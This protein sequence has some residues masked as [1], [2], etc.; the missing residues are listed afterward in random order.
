MPK[1]TPEQWPD[2]LRQIA[3]EVAA[4][5]KKSMKEVLVGSV[6]S[7]GLSL[8]TI[9]N[10]LEK[11]GFEK[12]TAAEF[13]GLKTLITEIADTIEPPRKKAPDKFAYPK[14]LTEFSF[15]YWFNYFYVELPNPARRQ[16]YFDQITN[17][18]GSYIAEAALDRRRLLDEMRREG[19]EEF[20]IREKVDPEVL[21]KDSAR[22]YQLQGQGVRIVFRGD[23][24]TPQQ[25]ENNQ[26]TLP[27]SR[28]PHLRQKSN[29]DQDWHP[30]NTLGNKVFFRKGANTDNCLFTAISVTPEF[31]TATKFP[32]QDELRATNPNALG[33]ATVEVIPQGLGTGKGTKALA[34][35]Y[36]QSHKAEVKVLPA[37]K[38]TIYVVKTTGGWNTQERQMQL[39]AGSFPEYAFEHIPWIYHL[40]SV[41]VIRLHYGEEANLGHLIVIEGWSWLQPATLLQRLLGSTVGV[42]RLHDFLVDLQARGSAEAGGIPYLP[43]GT[44]PPEWKIQRIVKVFT[45]G[46]GKLEKNRIDSKMPQPSQKP[47]LQP[48]KQAVRKSD[49]SWIKQ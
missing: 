34:Q 8:M 7:P 2:L 26:G 42:T 13:R 43:P 36:I 47:V 6:G 23:G 16:F 11:K 32:L 49:T 27:Q 10:K 45:P 24:R 25:I 39:G 48:A 3:A 19:F 37:S 15:Q 38:T 46:V 40:A 29:M 35:N 20:T 41:P 17:V 14:P 30:F 44:D 33:T 5:T 28:I 4:V 21:Y 18:D 12:I 1:P 22:N 31:Y 9:N